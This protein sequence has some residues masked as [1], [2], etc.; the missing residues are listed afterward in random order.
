M[1][2]TIPSEDDVNN[3]CF[4]HGVDQGFHNYLIYSGLLNPYMDIKYY[5]QG[6]GMVGWI[7]INVGCVNNISF[8]L[9]IGP[10]NTLGA[11]YGGKA[12]LQHNLSVWKII[13]GSKPDITIH[14]WNGDL[15]PAVHQYDRFE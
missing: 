1:A 6:E 4:T 12:L 13:K 10:V 9:F 8:Y 11:F 5:P 14:N 2:A 15:S 7:C 3:R